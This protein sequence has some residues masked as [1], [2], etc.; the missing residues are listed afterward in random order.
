MNRAAPSFKNRNSLQGT[1]VMHI[2]YLLLILI[3]PFAGV[4]ILFLLSIALFVRIRFSGRVFSYN[5][6]AISLIFSLVLMLFVSVISGGS[7]FTYP[8][9]IVLAAFAIA[10]VGDHGTYFSDTDPVPD[11]TTRRSRIKKRSFSTLWSS[12]FLALRIVAAFLAASWII[13]WQGLL[14]SYNLVFFIAVIGAVTGSLFESIPSKIDKNISVPLGSGMTMWIFEEFRYWV[15]P[16]EIV[17]ALA[18]S[19]FLG[20]LAYRAKIADVSALLS[21]ALLGVLI[22]VFSG[23]SWF[24]LLLTFFILGGGFTRYKYAYKESIGIAQAKDGIRSYENVFSNSTA[25]LVLAVAYGVFPEHSLPIIYAYMG[26]VATATGDTLASEIGTTAKGRPRMI[27]TLK[28]SEPGADG[29]VSLLGE[30]AAILGS[31]VI[32]IL[33]YLLGVSDNFILTVLITTAGGFFGT[34][35]DSLLGATLQKRGVLSNSGVN[36]VATF[37]G[38]GISAAL[39]YL[40]A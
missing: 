6:S 33:A 32:G 40:I 36:F 38:A 14:V 4:N 16:E 26:T 1:P 11:F 39:Y 22:I 10:V 29:A 34:N 30:F 17:V 25:A 23:L 18:F 3:A 31:A 37:T 9:Y 12:A 19:F 21:A 28:P 20:V 13:Y 24:L 27:T 15:P 2:L 5:R 35:I 7:S 8:F